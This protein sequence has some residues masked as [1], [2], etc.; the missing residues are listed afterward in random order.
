[1]T[2]SF[3]ETTLRKLVDRNA[4]FVAF[5]HPGRQ[6]E[7]YIQLDPQ[8]SPFP[9]E[10]KME[11][12]C[13]IFH[14]FDKQSDSTPVCI[15]PDLQIA[16][17]GEIPWKKIGGSN[18]R[19]DRAPHLCLNKEHYLDQL[20][21]VKQLLAS[22]ELRKLVFSRTVKY[23]RNSSHDPAKIF[24][25]L[26]NNYPTAFCYLA[27]L[28]GI[29]MWCGATPETLLSCDHGVGQ[30]MAL[31]GTRKAGTDA[32]WGE[33]EIEEQELVADY[34]AKCLVDS[35]ATDVIRSKAQTRQAGKMEHLLTN[36]S[37]RI[38]SSDILS[39]ARSLHPTPAVAGIPTQK[40]IEYIRDLELR[41]RQYY[42]GFLGVVSPGNAKLYVNLR[43]MQIHEE[44]F[45]LYV[46][47]GI[48]AASQPEKE[49]QETD[50]KAQTLLSVIEKI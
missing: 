31:A 41:D 18:D 8:P 19:I 25:T 17:D 38:S 48:T 37:F 26:R 16:E 6:T 33:K 21:Q 29:G 27:N 12:A 43:C 14:P 46:G 5:Q 30:T 7:L 28:S 35:G 10:D 42:A 39:T 4:C 9:A 15:K 50:L 36:F 1:M 2:D 45:H 49:W 22:G 11:N 20:D 32:D 44:E 23:P 47:G 40:S 34:I 24:V 13:F 3:L